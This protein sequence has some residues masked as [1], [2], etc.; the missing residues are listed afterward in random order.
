[1][2]VF[3]DHYTPSAEAA[4]TCVSKDVDRRAPLSTQ[5]RCSRRVW[6][7]WPPGKLVCEPGHPGPRRPLRWRRRVVA[8]HGTVV[9]GA[10][11]GLLGDQRPDGRLSSFDT[12]GPRDGR[13]GR[14]PAARTPPVSGDRRPG[15]RGDWGRTGVRRWPKAPL[16]R[17]QRGRRSSP[18]GPL[19]VLVMPPIT[20]ETARR[21]KIPDGASCPRYYR[22]EMT[23]VPA[24]SL[25]PWDLQVQAN[26]AVW[27]TLMRGEGKDRQ[28][29]YWESTGAAAR[30][31]AGARC[32]SCRTPTARGPDCNPGARGGQPSHGRCH[33][34]PEPGRGGSIGSTPTPFPWLSWP[35]LSRAR[36]TRGRIRR[37]HRHPVRRPT[38]TELDPMIGMVANTDPRCASLAGRRPDL[39]PSWSDPPAAGTPPGRGWS[40]TASSSSEKL[41]FGWRGTRPDAAT[42]STHRCDPVQFVYGAMD[43]GRGLEPVRGGRSRR[44]VLLGLPTHRKTRPHRCTPTPQGGD[45]TTLCVESQHDLGSTEPWADHGVPARQAGSCSA[46]GRGHATEPQSQTCRYSAAEQ[47]AMN[48]RARHR[49]LQTA[50]ADRLELVR[51]GDPRC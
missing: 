34:D 37:R 2:Y 47:E 9:H 16:M 6:S 15:R 24:R 10:R 33:R 20:T 25:P 44:V 50:T 19:F 3:S 4:K 49:R 46:T 30:R 13:P 22:A 14:G 42:L 11:R 41:V 23:G 29:G 48:G 39:R 12:A 32:D 21:R 8:D 5:T 27:Q 7:R 45:T 43:R 51:D 18:T 36:V 31:T 1:M 26:Y 28:L 38:H 40:T 35:G 17:G